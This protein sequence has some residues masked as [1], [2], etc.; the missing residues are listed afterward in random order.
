MVVIFIQFISNYQA[1]LSHL[2][3]AAYCYRCVDIAWLSVCTIMLRTRNRAI[4]W[5]YLCDP[6]FIAVLVK[7]RLVTDGPTDR[8]TTTAYTALT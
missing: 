6:T 8:R 7:C 1:A 5:R 3:D 4:V 2:V